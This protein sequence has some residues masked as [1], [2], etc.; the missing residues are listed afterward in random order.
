MKTE[1]KAGKEHNS[2][3]DQGKT[4]LCVQCAFYNMLF[5]SGQN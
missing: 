1:G 4:T 2:V 5:T 3:L